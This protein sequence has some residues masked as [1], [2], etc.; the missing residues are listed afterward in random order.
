MSNKQIIL[1][2]E[3]PRGPSELVEVPVTV[4]G[5]F[6]VVF[7]DNQQLRSLTTQTIV[8]KAMR[9][10]APDVLSFATL[11]G[12]PTSPVTEIVKCVLVL[13][14]E[15]WEKAHYIPL[16]VLNDTFASNSATPHRYSSTRFSD[17]KNVDW[18][19]SYIQYSNGSGGSV[20]AG[21][22]PYS[23]LFD[24]EYVKQDAGGAEIVGPS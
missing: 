4:A 20:L 7:P 12:N 24:V 17:W 9:L 8:I 5:T 15:G 6:K 11:S 13:Y 22:V 21:A 2:K 18:S 16:F 14:C 3:E 1:V 23:F 10:I 19:K